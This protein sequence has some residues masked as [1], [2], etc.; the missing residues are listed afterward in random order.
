[1]RFT[2][3]HGILRFPVRLRISWVGRDVLDL[4][5][6]NTFTELANCELRAAVCG[7]DGGDAMSS[8]LHF[9]LGKLMTDSEVF[10]VN[11]ATSK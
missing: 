7:Q 6:L 3:L 2:S 4:P 11:S 5:H 9:E 8:E 10:L 1:M